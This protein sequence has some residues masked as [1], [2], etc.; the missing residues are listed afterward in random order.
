MENDDTKETWGKKRTI[1]EYESEIVVMSLYETTTSIR[2]EGNIFM[3]VIFFHSSS[4][5][6]NHGLNFQRNVA[7][8]SESSAITTKLKQ[9]LILF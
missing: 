9:N 5:L 8:K 6:I 1:R 4:G 2:G 7:K 3:M